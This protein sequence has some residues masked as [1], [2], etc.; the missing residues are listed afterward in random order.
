[1]KH[2]AYARYR[3]LTFLD[4]RDRLETWVNAVGEFFT[5]NIDTK[6]WAHVYVENNNHQRGRR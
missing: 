6:A 4:Y 3:R 2:K 5:Y 1:M